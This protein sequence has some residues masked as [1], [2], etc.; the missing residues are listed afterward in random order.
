MIKKTLCFSN[1]AYLSMKNGQMVDGVMIKASTNAEDEG[2]L[3]E[4]SLRALQ[5]EGISASSAKEVS[6]TRHV[7]EGKVSQ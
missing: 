1:P 3:S 2:A 4:E 6:G 5:S 7:S